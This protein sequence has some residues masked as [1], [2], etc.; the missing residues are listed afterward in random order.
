MEWF[1]YYSAWMTFLS[2]DW[3]CFD[4]YFI[5]MTIILEYIFCMHVGTYLMKLLAKH[6]YCMHDVCWLYR[7]QEFDRPAMSLGLMN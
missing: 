5:N 3:P 1:S 7:E 6:M 2:I 4:K